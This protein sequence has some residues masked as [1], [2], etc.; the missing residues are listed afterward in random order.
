MPVSV[1]VKLLGVHRFFVDDEGYVSDL[2]LEGRKEATVIAIT[3]CF[4]ISV[5]MGDRV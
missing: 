2:V 1:E 4:L 5:G 3:V